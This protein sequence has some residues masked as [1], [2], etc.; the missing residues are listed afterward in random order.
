MN[1]TLKTDTAAEQ[2]VVLKKLT[3]PME[4]YLKCIDSLEL[5]NKVARVSDIS[6]RMNVRKAIVD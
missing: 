6:R 2:P 1:F 4:D 3:G 5:E